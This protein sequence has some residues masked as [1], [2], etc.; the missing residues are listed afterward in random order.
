MTPKELEEDPANLRKRQALAQP[1][2]CF[3]R[4]AKAPKRVSVIEG[5]AFL[6]G[7][8]G[9]KRKEMDAGSLPATLE[10]CDWAIPEGL[11]TAFRQAAK[12][13]ASLPK[14]RGLAPK[15]CP[16]RDA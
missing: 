15:N 10:V 1:K 14:G 3:I 16:H 7:S 2:T 9:P 6:A 5:R 11:A 12:A 4:P 8:D 13:Q